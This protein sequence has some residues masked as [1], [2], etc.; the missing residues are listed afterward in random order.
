MI[1]F[2][3]TIYHLVMIIVDHRRHR[4]WHSTGLAIAWPIISIPMIG[5]LQ[6]NMDP[7]LFGIPLLILFSTVW[8]KDRRIYLAGLLLFYA[9]C[10]MVLGVAWSNGSRIHWPFILL[11]PVS[12]ALIIYW[13]FTRMQALDK[14]DVSFN[15]EKSLQVNMTGPSAKIQSRGRK[16]V[17][18]GLPIIIAIL[19]I[20]S[21]GFYRSG[22]TPK[23]IPESIKEPRVVLNKIGLIKTQALQL[24]GIGKITDIVKL[25]ESSPEGARLAIAGIGGAALTDDNLSIKKQVKY[26]GKFDPVSVV[27]LNNAGDLGYISRGAW[28]SLPYL[29]DGSGKQLWKYNDG[30]SG[31]DDMA[32]GDLNG[33][34]TPEFAVG[35]NGGGGGHLLNADGKKVWAQS[36]ANVWHLEIVDVD[37][38]GH[39]KIVHSNAA[40]AITIRDADGRILS[41]HKPETYF[42]H[43]SII[44]LPDFKNL[45]YLLLNNDEK[46]WILNFKGETIK[47][48]P[49]IFSCDGDV[50]GNV[51]KLDNDNSYIAVIADIHKWDRSVLYL[52]NSSDQLIY[53]E[54]LPEACFSIYALPSSEG[55]YQSLLVG[56][57][58]TVWQYKL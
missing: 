18:I 17:L 32:A 15:Q 53:Q 26:D 4:N 30:G 6:G 16:A 12:V 43:F 7:P 38:D 31:V 10:V 51:V 19:L 49:S 41:K 57:K 20:Y 58:D 9:L 56:C 1:G 5:V 46:I 8:W 21:I 55:S 47:K 35:F 37:G 33:D 2:V 27:R 50:K 52:Y 25:Q 42:A 40:G 22:Y 11:W 39:P 36:D 14:Q 45:P 24:A 23:P 54:I 13:R 44:N 3:I 34:G 48:L 28:A 29:M